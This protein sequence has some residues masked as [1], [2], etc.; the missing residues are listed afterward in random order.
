MSSARGTVRI[1]PLGLLSLVVILCFAVMAVLAVATAQAAFV[2]AE[3]QARFATDSYA[4]ET[5]AQGLVA[6]VDNALAPVRAEH[7]GRDAALDA[8]KRALGP[9]NEAAVVDDRVNAVFVA[10]SGRTLNVVLLINDD[11]TYTISQWKTTTQW[12]N[13]DSDDILWSGASR[14]R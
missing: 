7:G 3:K 9:S 13:S 8:V 5:A 11:A 12:D 14:T 1:G 6:E 2:T 4:N 10:D